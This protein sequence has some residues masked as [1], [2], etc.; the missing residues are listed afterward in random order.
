MDSNIAHED[1]MTKRR[2]ML[3]ERKKVIQ[4]F[5]V[6]DIAELGELKDGTLYVKEGIECFYS[7]SFVNFQDEITK[8]VFPSTLRE[9][10]LAS[11][12]VFQT[13]SNAE[14]GVLKDCKVKSLDFSACTNPYVISNSTFINFMQLKEVNFGL[15]LVE[16]GD[17]AFEHCY[18][19]EMIELSDNVEKIGIGAFQACFRLKK[20][21]LGRKLQGIPSKAFFCCQSLREVNLG[22]C[23]EFIADEA[24][25]DC[26]ELREI[27]LSQNVNTVW[28]EAFKNCKKLERIKL[29]RELCSLRY[30]YFSPCEALKEI[31]L[32]DDCDF[33][34]FVGEVLSFIE[35][36]EWHKNEN[37]DFRYDT[38]IKIKFLEKVWECK[39]LVRVLDIK[40]DDTR[41]Y[42]LLRDSLL[43]KYP[44]QG[45]LSIENT[46]LI[47][48]ELPN[49]I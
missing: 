43:L 25:Y 24:F 14:T 18:Q 40:R 9:V 27:D 30:D 45:I 32:P 38:E 37:Y 28:S 2:R 42:E 5:M 17:Y 41:Y 36:I 20:A 23:V 33:R 8:I 26:S 39:E 48:E 7:E 19:L 15:N 4:T 47:D 46:G 13:L 49:L 11:T 10:R 44:E 22:P 12:L 34:L 3:E 31:V 6:K 16:I 35:D 21:S 29:G 1:F